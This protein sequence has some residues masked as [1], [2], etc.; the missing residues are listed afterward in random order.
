MV[1]ACFAMVSAC[2]AALSLSLVFSSSSSLILLSR[3]A[4]SRADESVGGWR[5]IGISCGLLRRL[6]RGDETVSL[7]VPSPLTSSWEDVRDSNSWC[8][9]EFRCCV[10]WSFLANPLLERS[11]CEKG[12]KWLPSFLWVASWRARSDFLLKGFWQFEHLQWKLLACWLT[13][14]LDEISCQHHPSNELKLSTY[15][16]SISWL[17]LLFWQDRLLQTRAVS[18]VCVICTSSFGAFGNRWLEA[19]AW[20]FFG[21]SSSLV[22]FGSGSWLAIADLFIGEFGKLD[23][24]LSVIGVIESRDMVNA[25][26]TEDS[27]LENGA[28][29]DGVFKGDMECC[30]WIGELAPERGRWWREKVEWGSRVCGFNGMEWPF[31]RIGSM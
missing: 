16:L 28:C 12:Q 3:W 14:F 15:I 1:S 2:L 29:S 20:E 5:K 17:N 25:W 6:L 26:E 10:R 31:E 30:R 9:F 18:C 21:T 19:I 4:L 8:V 24:S 23:S 11:Q 27:P 22:C 13:W 7:S